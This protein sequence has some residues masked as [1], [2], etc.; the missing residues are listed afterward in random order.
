MGQRLILGFRA[1]VYRYQG[2]VQQPQGLSVQMPTTDVAI[3]SV[4]ESAAAVQ[5]KNY[6]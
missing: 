1:N 3:P 4:A 5:H 6:I 2:Q